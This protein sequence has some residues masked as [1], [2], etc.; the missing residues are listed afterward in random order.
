M[1]FLKFVETGHKDIYDLINYE[2]TISFFLKKKTKERK[3]FL[4]EQKREFLFM[5][6]PILM[7]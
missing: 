2:E 6:L 1:Q 7:P 3:F 4:K 5:L